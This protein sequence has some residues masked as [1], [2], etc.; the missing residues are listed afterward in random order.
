MLPRVILHNIASLDGRTDG[1]TPDLG[2]FYQ[3][4]SR[5]NED[6][7]LSGCDTLL[8]AE[9]GLAGADELGGPPEGVQENSSDTRPLLVV[10]DSRGRLRSWPL[11][12]KQPYWRAGL[13]LCSKS[14]PGEYLN[15]LQ[16]QGI[17]FIISGDDHVDFRAALEELNTRHGVDVIRVDSGGTLNGVLLKAGLV[18]EISLLI[19]P[20]LADGLTSRPLFRSPDVTTA[21]EAI[22]LQLVHFER[23]KNDVIWLRY[24]IIRSPSR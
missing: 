1:F 9:L 7:T 4:A 6:A 22:Q 14:T 13:A 19:H 15:Y 5:W 12:R 10:P 24:L 8:A 11:W 20:A 16:S 17:D 3:L 2:Q 18:D 23:L 21:K